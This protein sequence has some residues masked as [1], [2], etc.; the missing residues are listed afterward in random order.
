MDSLL[1]FLSA[2]LIQYLQFSANCT[3]KRGGLSVSVVVLMQN[4]IVEHF[5]Y[6]VTWIDTSNAKYVFSLFVCPK[7]WI[8]L[9]STLVK[10]RF[11]C[12]ERISRTDD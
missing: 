8:E 6:N 7:V 4:L 12:V 5:S 1:N 2:A 3:G 9:R 11:Q 10:R